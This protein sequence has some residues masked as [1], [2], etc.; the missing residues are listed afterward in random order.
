MHRKTRYMYPLLVA[1]ALAGCS[2]KDRDSSSSST[3]SGVAAP[4]SSMFQGT[5]GPVQGSG[6]APG[7]ISVAPGA[8]TT[9]TSPTGSPG[10]TGNQSGTPA[11]APGM[12]TP[13]GAGTNGTANPYANVG[14]RF[15]HE[16]NTLGEPLKAHSAAQSSLATQIVSALNAERTKAGLSTLQAEAVAIRAAK[17]HSEDMLGRGYF[18]HLTPEGWTP[19]QRYS[20]L[21]GAGQRKVAE[22]LL[23]GS[24][25]PAQIVA[26]WM[27]S[28]GHRANILDPDMNEVG[29][30]LAA[31][32]PF[33][34][35][36]FVQR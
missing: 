24:S 5:N 11:F 23:R 21:G 16:N 12:V 13:I 6:S 19:V 29:V 9:N 15:W 33:V 10:T 35:A 7:A 30:G 1:A 4:T 28:P 3:Q 32:D 20:M 31:S 18:D 25:D 36:V 14:S 2:D 8:S 22:N 34:T 27:A 17:A 26:A